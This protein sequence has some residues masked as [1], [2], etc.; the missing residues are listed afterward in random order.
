MN[1]T[2]SQ[3]TP[4]AMEADG[5]AERLDVFQGAAKKLDTIKPLLLALNPQEVRPFNLSVPA[6]LSSAIRIW[7]SYT[8]DK[9]RFTA[10]FTSEGFDSEGLSDFPL[11]IAALWYTDVQAA[12]YIFRD[13]PA[14]KRRYPSLFTYRT[15]SRSRTKPA[16][17]EPPVETP[18]AEEALSVET[19]TA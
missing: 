3:Q 12:L 14:A 5:S 19:P 6:T 18:T 15:S 8:G 7:Q 13:D 11:R 4:G 1:N 2:I 9:E 10:S 16:Q 17:T